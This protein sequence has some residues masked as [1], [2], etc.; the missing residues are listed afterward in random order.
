MAG[1]HRKFQMALNKSRACNAFVMASSGDFAR[2][3]TITLA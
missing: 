3:F 1:L 2:I